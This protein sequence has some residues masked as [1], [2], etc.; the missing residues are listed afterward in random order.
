MGTLSGN[1]AS[2]RRWEETFHTD[3]ELP[4][5]AEE[6]ILSGQASKLMLFVS[7]INLHFNTNAK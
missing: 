7:D 2:E 6:L 1:G 4:F 5:V 3:Q